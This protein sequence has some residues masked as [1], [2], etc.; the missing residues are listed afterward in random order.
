MNIVDSRKP[1]YGSIEGTAVIWQEL[2][3]LLYS[4][5]GFADAPPVVRYCLTTIAMKLARSANG[6]WKHGD[7]WRDIAE[8]ARVIAEK[9][10][11]QEKEEQDNA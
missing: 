8:C 10:E 5:E 1:I 6:T 9:A 7:G 3:A 4:K 2:L 11:E